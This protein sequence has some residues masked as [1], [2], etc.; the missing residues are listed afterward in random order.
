MPADQSPVYRKFSRLR[1]S[2]FQVAQ[3]WAAPDHLM[4]VTSIYAFETYRRFYFKDIEALVIRRTKSQRTWIVTSGI[5]IGLF[6]IFAAL[7]VFAGRRGKLSDAG[8]M[9]GWA[10]FCGFVAGFFLIVLIW[11]LVLG[12]TCVVFLQMPAGLVRLPL[13]DR[14]RGALKMRDRLAQAMAAIA[15]AAPAPAEAPTSATP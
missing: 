1:K 6:I 8:T 9:E 4:L 7:F 11:Q 10:I 2:L 14:L 13:F 3:L 15:P 5:V 12:P